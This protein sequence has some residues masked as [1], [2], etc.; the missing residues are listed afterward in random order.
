MN[1]Y[2]PSDASRLII[3]PQ[4]EIDG[5]LKRQGD[6]PG[7]GIAERFLMFLTAAG[8][9]HLPAVAEVRQEPFPLPTFLEKRPLY[10]APGEPPI[11]VVEKTYTAPV[12][13]DALEV[14]VA[15]GARQVFAFGVCGAVGADV[16]IGDIV[17]PT[18]VV[19]REGTSLHYAPPEVNATPDDA[20]RRRLV[21]H[22]AAGE[23]PVHVG[24]TVSTDAPFRQTVNTELNWRAAGVLG[25]D[26][27]MSA[28]LTVARFHRVP[29]VGLLVVSDKHDLTETG[30]W[31]YGGAVYQANRQAAV[32]QFVEFVR[33]T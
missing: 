4:A 26:M 20:L 13:V 1:W 21:D 6:V 7:F 14:A 33:A 18:E 9:R 10:T 23:T 2:D 31:T 27:E 12:A 5:F 17:I 28:I 24:K 22:F 8:L 3:A 32:E 11:S 25:V 15:L 30:G 29:A 19:R 16:E